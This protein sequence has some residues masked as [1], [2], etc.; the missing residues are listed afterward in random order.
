MK[1]ERSTL[2][3]MTE[4]VQDGLAWVERALT[5]LTLVD[6]ILLAAAAALTYYLWASLRALTRLGPI[7]VAELETDSDALEA[8]SWTAALREHLATAGLM[9]SPEVPA[10]APQTD[11]LAAIEAS[12]IQQVNWL[13]STM[14]LVPRPRPPSYQLKGTLRAREQHGGCTCG[15]TYWLQ[16]T[17]TGSQTEVNTVWNDSYAHAVQ[18]VASNVCIA[19]T[20]SAVYVYPRW[21]RWSNREAFECYSKGLDLL[22][23]SR[24]RQDRT[25][26][27]ASA[28]GCH[29]N[30]TQG[31]PRN[32]LPRL[33]IAN[34]KEK[35]AALETDE[36][37]ST[38][39]R[40][41]AVRAYRQIADDVP[42]LVEARFRASVLLS[43]LV[44]SRHS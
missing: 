12:P 21:A 33:Q 40:I 27:Y 13:A 39:L 1:E 11:L 30:A 36:R 37:T 5:G 14:R 32:L 2:R 44:P 15:V 28:L 38:D 35:Q 26:A 7:E 10:G 23:A 19:I 9:A 34:I 24:R 43:M 16:D 29:E 22:A 25:E 41:E 4:A 31:E 42:S 20:N 6:W 3:S 8:K 18:A 17:V